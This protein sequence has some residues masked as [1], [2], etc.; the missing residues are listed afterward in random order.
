MSNSESTATS[1]EATS[2]NAAAEAKRGRLERWLGTTTRKIVAT[3]TAL[4][5]I[6]ALVLGVLELWDRT[7][8]PT[9]S[10]AATIATLEHPVLNQTLGQF[11]GTHPGAFPGSFS[12][13]ERKTNGDTFTVQIGLEGLEGKDAALVWEQLDGNT[14]EPLPVASWVPRKIDL[15]AASDD[16]HLTREVWVPIPSTGDSMFVRFSVTVPSRTNPLKVEDGAPVTI[17]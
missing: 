16:D 1:N 3:A 10:I 15:D 13:A 4:G 17:G 5:A 9:K 14:Q 6:V 11:V 7:H 2:S 12:A 8:A